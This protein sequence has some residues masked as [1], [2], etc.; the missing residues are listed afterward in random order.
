MWVPGV[1]QNKSLDLVH[2]FRSAFCADTN[3]IGL[4]LQF[5]FEWS[6]QNG[7][8]RVLC[9]S[10]LQ[11]CDLLV[12]PVPIWHASGVRFSSCRSTL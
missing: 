10:L 7:Y 12:K 8:L 4:L 2:N 3:E 11:C 6:I 5:S 9:L 1:L